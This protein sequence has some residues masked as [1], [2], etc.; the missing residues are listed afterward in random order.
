[1]IVVSFY[2]DPKTTPAP[3]MVLKT[4][5]GGTIDLG[6][7]YGIK[8]VYLKFWATWCA[9]CRQQMPGFEDIY[10]QYGD[11][12]QVIAVNIGVSDDV[13]SVGDFVKKAGLTMPITIDDGKLARAFHLR[14]TPQHL[15]IDNNANIAYVGHKD[16]QE[17]HQA[18]DKVIAEKASGKIINNPVLAPKDSGYKVGDSLPTQSFSTIDKQ[19]IDLRF[20]AKR[21]RQV[22]LVFFGPWCEWYLETTEPKTSQACTRV[23]ELLEQK[24]NSASIE[25]I[26]V[27]TNLWSSLAD[28]Q[29]YRRNY[30][31]TLPIVFDE[32]G[33]LFK[34]FG[35]N[36][37]PT[38]MLIDPNGKVTVKSS[39]Q[40]D[41]FDATLENLSHLK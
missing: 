40:D 9:P 12:I 20:H 28:L 37:V 21:S 33:T 25:W 10:Q 24:A 35:V 34:T 13:K 8:P 39:I 16:D 27:S 30:G 19:V 36:Q 2:T 5:D 18:L 14:V 22:G 31:T 3:Q 38:I 4:L 15:L 7:V 6:Q 23:R 17:F 26:T 1:M 32:E 29:D 41:N 11:K